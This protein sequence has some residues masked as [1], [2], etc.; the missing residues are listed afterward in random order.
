MN[1]RIVGSLALLLVAC[2]FLT[3]FGKKSKKPEDLMKIAAIGGS[4]VI[5]AESFAAE[6]MMKFAAVC[7]GSGAHLTLRHAASI[8]DDNLFKIAAVGS[9]IVTFD[10]E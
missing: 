2:V 8:A 6:D 4:L 5:D 10:F 3:G 9:G 7:K 1:K